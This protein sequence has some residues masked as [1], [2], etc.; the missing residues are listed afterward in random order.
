MDKA[1]FGVGEAAVRRSE[2]LWA[3]RSGLQGGP[4]SAAYILARAAIS[5]SRTSRRAFGRLLAHVVGLERGTGPVRLGSAAT[6]PVPDLSCSSLR[7]RPCAGL[8]RPAS[9]A[10]RITTEVMRLPNPSPDVLEAGRGELS[11]RLVERRIAATQLLAQVA[12]ETLHCAWYL[13][14]TVGT[15]RVDMIAKEAGRSALRQQRQQTALTQRLS[16]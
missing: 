12:Y 15:N 9:G 1:P 10:A 5:R 11:P 2:L 16:A 6:T 13:R 7:P 4:I 3:W 14:T 8:H